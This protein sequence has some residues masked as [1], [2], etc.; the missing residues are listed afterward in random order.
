MPRVALCCARCTHSV[1]V[2]AG[3]TGRL[4]THAQALLALC[5]ARAIKRAGML[6]STVSP[7]EPHA[8]KAE[9]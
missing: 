8:S 2:P 4:G 3:S 5:G 9:P 1:A 7:A 6:T